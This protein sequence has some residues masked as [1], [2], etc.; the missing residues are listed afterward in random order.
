MKNPRR[1]IV[2]FAIA[3]V[4]ASVVYL[5]QQSAYR[6]TTNVVGTVG[7]CAAGARM[8]SRNIKTGQYTFRL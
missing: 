7:L 4:V 8:V 2:V 1:D 6:E 5:L 3:A